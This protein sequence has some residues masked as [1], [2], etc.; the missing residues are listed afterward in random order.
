[1]AKKEK[2]TMGTEGGP[3]KDTLVGGSGDDIITGRQKG[4]KLTGGG[5]S[6]TYVLE[7][8]TDSQLPNQ[9]T[10]TDWNAD[11]RLQLK[12]GV[13]G[14]EDLDND[15]V[16]ELIRPTPADVTI[17]NRGDPDKWRISIFLHG[18]KPVTVDTIGTQPD[19]SQIIFWDGVTP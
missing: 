11:S 15:G 5:G 10:I 3:G 2:I 13:F 14:A 18:T 7:K 19:V 8:Y 1:M 4:D 17:S 9:D 16:A 6:D 12:A